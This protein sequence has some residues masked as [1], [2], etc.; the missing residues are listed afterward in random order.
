MKVIID[1]PDYGIVDNILK[2][3]ENAQLLSTELKNIKEILIGE[4][5]YLDFCYKIDKIFNER[6]RELE[7][8]K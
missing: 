8:D 7:E 2:A 4:C 3:C 1:M 5:V 6:I